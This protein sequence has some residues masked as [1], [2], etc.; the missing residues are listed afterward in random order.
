MIASFPGHH[1]GSNKRIVF[2]EG[3]D[4][5]LMTLD[6]QDLLMEGA[7]GATLLGWTADLG[8]STVPASTAYR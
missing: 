4:V 3:L 1:P 6:L 2:V 7:L 8:L 5:L